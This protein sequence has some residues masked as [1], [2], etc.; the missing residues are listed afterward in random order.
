MRFGGTPAGWST[1]R[2]SR[3]LLARAPPGPASVNVTISLALPHTPSWGAA[4]IPFLYA[5]TVA[6][7]FHPTLGAVGGG[8][9]VSVDSPDAARVA[10]CLFGE[11]RVP[12]RRNSDGVP[13]CLTP[14]S[15]AG[16]AN[17]S[18]LLTDRRVLPGATPFLFVD[19]VAI[20][21][22]YPTTGPPR[23]GTRVAVAGVGFISGAE[24]RF[25]G[26]APTRAEFGT[27][28][29]VTCV[30]PPAEAGFASLQVLPHTHSLSHTHTHI[31]SL[32]VYL[33]LS[34]SLSLVLSFSPFLSP[35]LPCSL[36]LSFLSP[37]LH[38]NPKL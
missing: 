20:A 12:A 31:L 38:L 36:S 25:G 26:A 35:F 30:A 24:C 10:A 22:L 32:Y 18:L 9:L 16:P 7:R 23:G 3:L 37:S 14:R 17:F 21:S 33:S 13:E 15:P 2:N 11:L 5:K 27:A 28:S 34:L 4:G 6:A 19:E 29:M 8:S 1:L